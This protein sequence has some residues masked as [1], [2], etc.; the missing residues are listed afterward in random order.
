MNTLSASGVRL[1]LIIAG[2]TVVMCLV[3]TMAIAAYAGRGPHGSPL[4]TSSCA[5]P[6]L[7]GT[8]VDVTLTD[9]GGMMASRMAGNG[10][11]G[12]GM[13]GAGMMQIVIN[14]AI[15]PA[16][17]VSFRVRNAG[18]LVHEMAVLALGAGESPGQ[19]AIGADGEVDETSALG[20]AAQTCGPND[21]DGILPGSLGWTTVT[22]K[23]GRYELLCNMAGHYGFGMYA[24]LTVVGNH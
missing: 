7:T 20:H 23:P 5:A 1:I 19:L 11:M 3:T 21:G 13:M 8:V 9:M 2:A 17:P 4:S 14:P 6:E 22:L 12:R 18:T 15:V 10:P 24:E 16:G